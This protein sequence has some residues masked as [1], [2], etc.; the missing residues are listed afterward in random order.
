[1]RPVRVFH[2]DT[3]GC[4]AC[5]AELWAT[6]E[7]SRELQWAPGPGQADVVAL[8]GSI[9][10]PTRDAVLTLYYEFFAERVPIVAIGRCA[11]DG[12]PY[13]RGG[14]VALEEMRVQRTLEACPPLPTI[15]LDALLDVARQARERRR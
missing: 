1:M 7:S 13:G 9:L 5:A 3:G 10:P 15:I 11:V 4:G 2:L 6:V 12:S 8:T 14:I